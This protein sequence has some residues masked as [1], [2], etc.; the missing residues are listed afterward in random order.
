MRALLGLLI[1][2]GIFAMAAGWQERRTAE[3]RDQR[4]QRFGIPNTDETL[5]GDWSTLVLGRPSGAESGSH[6]SEPAARRTAP[7]RAAELPAYA[8]DTAFTVQE[9]QVLGVICSQH[10]GSARRA[11]IE[12]VAAYNDLASPDDIR[13]GQVLLLPDEALLF[14]DEH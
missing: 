11:L 7:I 10:Y 12:A 3:L 13:E 5:D 9:N 8:A 2:A 6:S 4:S 1:L 14:P